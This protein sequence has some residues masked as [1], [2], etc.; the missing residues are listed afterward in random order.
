VTTPHWKAPGRRPPLP[1]MNDVA[2]EAGVALKTVSRF[3]NGATNIDPVLSARI[4]DAIQTLGYRRNLAA[5][6]I[7]PGHSSGV[8][9][10]IIGD[11]ANPYY[12]VLARA[13][14]TYVREQGYLLI[15]ASSDEDGALHD[16]LVDRLLDQRADGLLVVPP[17]RAARRWDQVLSSI[18][19]LVFLDRPAA[20]E[21]AD[22]VLADNEGGAYQA[23]QTLIACGARRVAFVGD[24]PAIYTM[25]ER[26]KGYVRAVQE[27]G[28][29][30]DHDLVRTNAHDAEQAT[31]TVAD[32]LARTGTDAVFAAN[33]RSAVGALG[34]FAS[35][36][37]RVALIGFDDFE[38]ASLV[39]PAVSV[40]RQPIV[41]MGHRAAQILMDRLSGGNSQATTHVLP[42]TLVIRGSEQQAQQVGIVI[43][44]DEEKNA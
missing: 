29:A 14:E 41:E 13:V 16:R 6:S 32:L 17:R 28:L 8:I 27:A 25:Q 4:D 3:V 40:V 9:G 2:R 44:R 12:S 10:M 42:T 19:P 21:Q 22:T 33:N 18:P 20:F 26:F 43:Q 11:L 5:A 23:T 31:T 35:A 7:R 36:R 15:T 1:T 39:Q 30:V 37:R 38:G 24:D 34:A